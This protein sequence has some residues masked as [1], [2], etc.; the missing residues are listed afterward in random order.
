MIGDAHETCLVAG[1]KSVVADRADAAVHL[2]AQ[3]ARVG[4]RLTI[5]ERRHRGERIGKGCATNPRRGKVRMPQ[6]KVPDTGDQSTFAAQREAML[7][8]P[9]AATRRGE[10]ACRLTVH[11]LV[12][13]LDMAS[14]IHAERRED[15]AIEELAQ[16]LSADVLHDAAEQHEVGVAVEIA[17]AWREIQR[18]LPAHALHQV[19]RLA[20]LSEID[21]A[22]TH[23]LQHVADAGGV[24][25]QVRERDAIAEV[26]QRRDIA[27]HI[28]VDRQLAFGRKQQDRSAGELLAD[29]CDAKGRL[30]HRSAREARCSPCRRSRARQ[31]RAPAPRQSSCQVRWCDATATSCARRGGAAA[32]GRGCSPSRLP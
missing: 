6:R 5:A 1:P 21:A 7:R 2:D 15:A 19:L 12:R 9:P 13:S 32:T 31:A 3:A 27:S 26:W 14:C 10:V 25:H 29:R 23:D 16:R 30:R 20:G 17:G 4:V 22:E 24:V 11:H 18:A 28:V 8:P